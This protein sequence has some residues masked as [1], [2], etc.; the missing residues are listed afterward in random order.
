MSRRFL[1]WTARRARWGADRQEDLALL[2]LGD[3][4]FIASVVT[5]DA[6]TGHYV[7]YYQ[8]YNQCQYLR[9]TEARSARWRTLILKS[10][11]NSSQS[12]N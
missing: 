7:C 1:H 2:S 5:S 3:N 8:R 12:A 10:L 9:Q 11:S 6:D 4:L